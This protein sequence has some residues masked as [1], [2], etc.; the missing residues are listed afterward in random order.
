[1]IAEGARVKVIDPSLTY[2]TYLAFLAKYQYEIN[3]EDL[4]K[5]RFGTAPAKDDEFTIVFNVFHPNTYKEIVSVIAND[6][7]LFMIEQGGLVEIEQPIKVG[8]RVVVTDT[9]AV[10]STYEQFVLKNK[11]KLESEDFWNFQ[12]NHGL[13]S[14]T[15]NVNVFEVLCIDRHGEPWAKGMLVA[16]IKDIV[17]HNVFVINVKDLKR[18]N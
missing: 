2:S 9:G 16:I 8:D 10:Y 7:N 18:V 11:D 6:T 14:C 5:F 1:M 17:D 15:E 4:R 12:Y 13:P 3:D